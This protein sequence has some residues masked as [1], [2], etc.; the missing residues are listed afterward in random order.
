MLRSYSWII[1]QYQI[2]NVSAFFW[3]TYLKL[4]RKKVKH[5]LA[6]G[7]KAYT[8][9]LKATGSSNLH[10]KTNS[11]LMML[12]LRNVMEEKKLRKKIIWL[13]KLVT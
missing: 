8:I 4:I 10:K 6:E 11:M 7:C 13:A 12:F 5:Q 1:I 9:F 3:S 2:Q